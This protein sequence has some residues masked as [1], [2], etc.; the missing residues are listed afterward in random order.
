MKK[1]LLIALLVPLGGCHLLKQ[2]P[3]FAEDKPAQAQALPDDFTARGT[4]IADYQILYFPT[5][6]IKGRQLIARVKRPGETEWHELYKDPDYTYIGE[7]KVTAGPPSDSFWF[8]SNVIK[9]GSSYRFNGP[10]APTGTQY[11][12]RS[13]KMTADHNLY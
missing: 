12:I 13:I 10:V 7:Y 6:S 11:E 9:D 1:L 5:G 8:R 3:G 4:T 2:V